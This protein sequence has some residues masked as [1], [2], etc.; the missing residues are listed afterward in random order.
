M[1]VYKNELFNV[2]FFFFLFRAT[3]AAYGSSWAR[4]RIRAPTPQPQQHPIRAA[5]ADY[6]TAHGNAG[7]STHWVRPGIEPTFSWTLVGFITHWAT[8]GTPYDA[9]FL[10][11]QLALLPVLLNLSPLTGHSWLD[12]TMAWRCAPRGYSH[13]RRQGTLLIPGNQAIEGNRHCL[14]TVV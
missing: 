9:D 7:S 11:Y 6:A 3:S 1:W 2:N 4:D 13:G 5:S 14:N 8:T 12:V 10:L